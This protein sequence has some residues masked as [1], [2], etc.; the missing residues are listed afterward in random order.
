MAALHPL[1][2]VRAQQEASKEKGR[3]TLIV[4]EHIADTLLSTG[5]FHADDLHSLGVPQQ[6]KA[7]IGS[8][9]AAFAAR[10]YMVEAGRRKCEHKAAN[11]RK[12]V[13]Y[14][15]TKLGREKLADV[16]H[17]A[18]TVCPG[19]TDRH[20]LLARSTGA[21]GETPERVIAGESAGPSRGPSVAPGNSQAEPPR[22][23]ALPPESALT[24][25]PEAA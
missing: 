23:F 4:R 10:G 15:I 8:Q 7:I 20:A 21:S 18:G 5:A 25:R 14:R 6:H 3:W 19:H 11:G 16:S 1:D 24:R 2:Q 22:L 17:S 12:A 13:V 9:I